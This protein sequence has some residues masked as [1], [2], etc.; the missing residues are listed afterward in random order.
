MNGKKAAQD[1]LDSSKIQTY[2]VG[3]NCLMAFHQF[4]PMYANGVGLVSA[5]GKEFL[6]DKPETIEGLQN[7]VDLINKYHVACLLYTSFQN[8]YRIR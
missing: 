6:W 3:F 2:G 7:V 8:L 5:D 4:W 1:G